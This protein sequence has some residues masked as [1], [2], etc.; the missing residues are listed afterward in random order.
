[1]RVSLAPTYLG[2]N[3]ADDG[4]E[5]N[6]RTPKELVISNICFILSDHFFY[7][8][9]LNNLYVLVSMV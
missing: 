2:L 5:I 9:G 8:T 3:E 1:L 7:N 4:F 6:Y